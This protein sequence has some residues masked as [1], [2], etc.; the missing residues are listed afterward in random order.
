MGGGAPV[1]VFVV[2]SVTVC[3]NE[4]DAWLGWSF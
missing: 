1:R 3:V 4:G 2:V